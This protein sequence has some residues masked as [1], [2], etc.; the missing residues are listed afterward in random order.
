MDIP[1]TLFLIG[2]EHKWMSLLGRLSHL[3]ENGD[4]VG[5][6]AVVVV[7]TAILS[8]RK[9]T[10][11]EDFKKRI[12]EFNQH[13]VAFFLCNNTVKKYG[14]MTDEFLPQFEIVKEGG[15]FK[16]LELQADGYCL[17]VMD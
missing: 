12:E 8:C 16:S 3:K 6:I 7:D 1:K 15:I 14:F 5:K 10:I 17:F 2:D 9:N 13:D 11:L 4:K